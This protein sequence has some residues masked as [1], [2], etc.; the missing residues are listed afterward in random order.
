SGSD[1][2]AQSRGDFGGVQLA[3]EQGLDLVRR[4][5][6]AA[7]LADQLAQRPERDALP[8]G[9][10][11]PGKNIHLMTETPLNLI[12]E[13]RLAYSCLADHRH[14]RGH[15]F[16]GGHSAGRRELPQLLVPAH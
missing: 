6:T 4:I 8:V 1:S 15:L 11:M 12:E 5:M 16:A 3:I 10:A 9:K 2:E 7:G 13:P 14:Q